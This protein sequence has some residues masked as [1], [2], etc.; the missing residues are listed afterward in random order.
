MAYLIELKINK[1]K[2]GVSA[3]SLVDTPAILT[4]FIKL[5]DEE[6]ERPM[7]FAMDDDKMIIVG[8]ALIPNIK[9]YRSA[10]SLGLDD[11][12]YVYF[13]EDTITDIAE[14]YLHELKNH[15]VTLD[16]ENKTDKVY[17]RESWIIEDVEFDK[18]LKY[19]FK[20]P[21]GTWMLSYKVEDVDLWKKI[22][23][24]EYNGFSIEGEAFSMVN[25]GEIH[26][27]D[28]DEREVLPD[29][30]HQP[31]IEH[32]KSKGK[33]REQMKKDG[34]V[35]IEI[36]DEDEKFLDKYE[37]AIESDP[38]ARS[39]LD[40]NNVAV[41]YE[42][43]VGAGQGAPIISTSRNFCRQVVGLDLIYR[44]EDIN[45][46]SF[47]SENNEFG[48]Y[49]IFRY[50][51]S[52]NCRHRWKR[53]VFAKDESGSSELDGYRNSNSRTLPYSPNDGEATTVNDKVQRLNKEF[54]K[55][56]TGIKSHK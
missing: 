12:G 8:P 4:N 33:T 39:F 13:S 43:R 24:G 29:H 49:S 9:I 42:Y 7:K 51:G 32:L 55:L 26:L 40:T 53:L 22:K 44:K 45:Q 25:I 5:K 1:D 48:T 37:L 46:M 23:S 31:V 35:E 11:E 16:H 36:D 28:E 30:L 15:E 34:W 6:K 56:L 47:R 20:L 27:H 41:R 38:E 3:V 18:S 17:L 10:E 50:K 21:K 14:L 54:N 52:F 19:G 2:K